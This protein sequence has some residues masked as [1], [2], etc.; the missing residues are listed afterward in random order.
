MSLKDRVKEA[1]DDAGISAADLARATK[2]TNAAVTFWLNGQTKT[3]KGEKAAMIE[4]ATGYNAQWII[5]GKGE[6]KKATGTAAVALPSLTVTA[7][8][9]NQAPELTTQCRDIA[10][11]LATLP[12]DPF[13]RNAVMGQITEVIA[14]ARGSPSSHQ[15]P[16]A[17][18][19]QAATRSAQG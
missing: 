7:S 8:A 6:K 19:S 12:D 2:S 15:E 4:T 13:V 11:M 17:Y 5:S 14:R 18:Q 9:T 10:A 3:L 1:M 16:P